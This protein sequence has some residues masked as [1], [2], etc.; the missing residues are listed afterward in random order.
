MD[1]IQDQWKMV[2]HLVQV[3]KGTNEVLDEHRDKLNRNIS[4]ED[5]LPYIPDSFGCASGDEA[6][7]DEEDGDEVEAEVIDENNK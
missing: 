6:D 5:K 1:R 7:S 4:D 2:L 3:G